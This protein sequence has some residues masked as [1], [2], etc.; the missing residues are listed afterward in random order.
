MSMNHGEN[1]RGKK[2]VGKKKHP[3]KE[4]KSW[5]KKP[6]RRKN[7]THHKYRGKKTCA[8]KEPEPFGSKQ[9]A[10][11]PVKKYLHTVERIFLKIP[12]N[13]MET[14]DTAN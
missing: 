6:P 10:H 14:L 2:F 13:Q 8:E 12:S 1:L 5:K 11:V 9:N 3:S 7:L 4:K